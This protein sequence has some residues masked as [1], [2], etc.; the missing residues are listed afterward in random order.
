MSKHSISISK[1]CEFIFFS[2]LLSPSELSPW[3]KVRCDLSR[4]MVLKTAGR[5]FLK[6]PM[7]TVNISY[8]GYPHSGPSNKPEISPIRKKITS[9]STATQVSL[10]KPVLRYFRQLQTVLKFTSNYNPIYAAVDTALTCSNFPVSS[11]RVGTCP[12]VVPRHTHLF[13]LS[14][15]DFLCEPP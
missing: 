15:L 4:K 5:I 11:A 10:S 1:A 9:D 13:R 3:A 8:F 14:P 6:R 2:K 7:E 12:S